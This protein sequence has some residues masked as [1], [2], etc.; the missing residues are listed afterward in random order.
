MK[1]CRGRDDIQTY[2]DDTNIPVLTDEEQKDCKGTISL[3]E[4]HKVLKAFQNNKS[5]G[6]D[7]LP[8]E[9]YKTFWP[10]FGSAMVNSFNNSFQKGEMS[11]SQRQAV[12]S[13]LDKGTDRTLLKN[14]RHISMSIVDYK[15]ASKNIAHRI[16]NYLP[17]LINNNQAGYVQNRNISENMRTIIDI[18]EYLKRENR[19]G[20]IINV[21]FEKAFDSVEWTF[22]KLVLKKFN[23]GS[24]V[25]QWFETF[26]KNIT[27]CVINKGITSHY[28][29]IERGVRQ[30]DPLSP[31]LFI[32]CAEILSRRVR[33]NE[34]IHGIKIGSLNVAL[35]QYAD[36]TSGTV[37][38]LNSAKQF[39]KKL[40][41]LDFIRASN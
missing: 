8:T 15:I 20:I 29:N 5:P 33:E 22:I 3:E 25:I 1:W 39:L 9:F 30:G 14:W 26:Y 28:F 23:F 36:D 11:P 17:K 24:S 37:L 34:N 32:L 38:D 7:G 27:N 41:R 35:L 10:D 2:L 12:I 19:S 13:L 21:D 16:T 40:K 6:N 18:M 4:C 31:Y